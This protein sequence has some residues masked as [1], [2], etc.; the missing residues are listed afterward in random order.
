LV[1]SL[2]RFCFGADQHE[3]LVVTV[4]AALPSAQNIN[5]YAGLYQRGEKLA[6]DGTLI[7][8]LLSVPV[9]LVVVLLT[10]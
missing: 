10:G 3:L 8:T 7:S 2:A 4:L 9:I 5:T 1:Y 6:R